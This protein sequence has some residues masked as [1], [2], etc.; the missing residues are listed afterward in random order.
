VLSEPEPREETEDDGIS[1]LTFTLHW[2]IPSHP[3]AKIK[4]SAIVRSKISN[5]E[6][7]LSQI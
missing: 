4:K 1:S 3:R 6:V 7:Q 2:E 5:V